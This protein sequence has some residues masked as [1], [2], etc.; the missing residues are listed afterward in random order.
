MGNGFPVAAIAGTDEVMGVLEQGGVGHGG[1]YCGNVVGAAAADATLKVLEEKPIIDSIYHYGELIM[2]GIGDILTRADIPHYVTG[3]A[4]MFSIQLGLADEPRDFRDYTKG[5]DVLYEKIAMGL[6][7][8]GVMPDADGREPW[9]VCYSHGEQEVG[10]T[11][12]AF[13]DAVKAAKNGR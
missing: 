5:D 10:D 13:E 12:T 11:L 1:T 8:R 9:F 3:P 6:I 2:K 7:D 4:P